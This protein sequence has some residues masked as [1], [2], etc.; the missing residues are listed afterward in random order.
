M[1]ELV[2]RFSDRGLTHATFIDA[3]LD[4]MDD[5]TYA[6]TLRQAWQRASREPVTEGSAEVSDSAASQ[7]PQS[8]AGHWS[9]S[10]AAAEAGAAAAGATAPG[11]GSG[12]CTGGMAKPRPITRSHSSPM[13][14]KMSRTAVS[15]T[16]AVT[17]TCQPT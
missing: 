17:S 11:F 14:S 6:A 1:G 4:S 15:L 8:F 5:V 2:T 12:N 16:S 10:S 13:K 9:A 7:W 3:A